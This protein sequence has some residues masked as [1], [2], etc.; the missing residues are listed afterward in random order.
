VNDDA[1]ID[2]IGAHNVVLIEIVLLVRCAVHKTSLL[3]LPVPDRASRIACV[4][5]SFLNPTHI[6]EVSDATRTADAM[7]DCDDS[8]PLPPLHPLRHPQIARIAA[9]YAA[10]TAPLVVEAAHV[11]RAFYEAV[12]EYDD[13][14]R[15]VR[16]ALRRHMVL[17]LV[18]MK[19]CEW[20]ARA[21]LRATAA[22]PDLLDKT[23]FRG[24][25]SLPS[26]ALSLAHK[27][28]FPEVLRVVC[29]HALP[30]AEVEVD[31]QQDAELSRNFLKWRVTIPGP[32]GSP[33]EGGRFV[34]SVKFP[35]D[36]PFMAPRVYF[37]TPVYHPNVSRSGFVG[38]P[39]LD[40]YSWSPARQLGDVLIAIALLLAEPNPD[41][42]AEVEIA[43]QC[44]HDRA[45]FDRAAR[46]ATARDAM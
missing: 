30:G 9:R 35:D 40:T 46:E 4:G 41:D 6:R 18:R 28:V 32:A 44:R 16:M 26:F 34:L 10:D 27:R 20:A 42:P 5:V 1:G 12:V 15:M 14:S 8:G 11:G 23:G 21:V 25:L 45:A 24:G 17:A 43:H 2:G 31:D 13:V 37:M 33:Y 19:R 39:I 3:S 29:G 22:H 38:V 7:S 36:Y